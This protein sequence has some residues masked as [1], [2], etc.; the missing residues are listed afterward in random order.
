[1]PIV[2]RMASLAFAIALGACSALSVVVAAEITSE[3]AEYKC[4]VRLASAAGGERSTVI[5][6][7]ELGRR[8][9]RFSDEANIAAAMIPRSIRTRIAEVHECVRRELVFR[10]PKARELERALPK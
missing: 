3:T 8:P 2:K 10:S 1:M 9:P 7:Y 5:Y 4:F 6:F